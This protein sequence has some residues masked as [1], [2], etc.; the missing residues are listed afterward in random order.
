[1]PTDRKELELFCNNGKKTIDLAGKFTRNDAG[2]IVWS[3]GKHKGTKVTDQVE[4]ARWVYKAEFPRNTKN[5]LAKI[6]KGEIK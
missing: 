4:Y 3:F 1:M 5:I 6:M 2:E